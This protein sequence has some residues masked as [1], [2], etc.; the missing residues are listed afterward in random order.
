ME[1]SLRDIMEKGKLN[2]GRSPEPGAHEI[3]L[4]SS[5]TY[6]SNVCSMVFKKFK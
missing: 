5:L 6:K 2:K 1:I 4:T 3:F